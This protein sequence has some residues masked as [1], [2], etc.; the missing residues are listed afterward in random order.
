MCDSVDTKDTNPR[1]NRIGANNSPANII[2]NP[3]YGDDDDVM[4][5]VNASNTNV[6]RQ[7]QG[8]TSVTVVDN[9]YYQ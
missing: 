9:L 3:Y 4:N 1:L 8:F 5:A 7:D 2:E 6:Q